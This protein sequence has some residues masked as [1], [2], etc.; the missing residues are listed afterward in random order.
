M[1]R[2]S[3]IS[4]CA[5]IGFKII[6]NWKLNDAAK[7]TTKSIYILF[8]VKNLK[9]FFFSLS[10]I[11]ETAVHTV[12]LTNLLIISYLFIDDIIILSF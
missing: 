5:P 9:K 2:H 11:Y 6:T 12:D 4:R 10:N 3:Q 7:R 1:S 8:H